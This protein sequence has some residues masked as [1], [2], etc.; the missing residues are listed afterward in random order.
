M[1]ECVSTQVNC[2]TSN[3]IYCWTMRQGQEKSQL[4]LAREELSV[5]ML[6]VCLFPVSALVTGCAVCGDWGLLHDCRVNDNR[7]Y[8]G[9]LHFPASCI[10]SIISLHTSSVS[11]CHSSAWNPWQHG[12]QSSITSIRL[13][14]LIYADRFRFC[15]PANCCLY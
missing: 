12:W 4:Q 8:F 10:Y 5:L 9:S 15:W 14:L 13:L 2:P 11:L 6:S 1:V 7:F 3:F